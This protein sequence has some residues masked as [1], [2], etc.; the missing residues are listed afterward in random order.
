MADDPFESEIER[1]VRI[2][3]D[4]RQITT[5]S[6]GFADLR[7]RVERGNNLKRDIV[8]RLDRGDRQFTRV[9]ERIDSVANDLHSLITELHIDQMSAD[10]KAALPAMAR[11]WVEETDQ[12]QERHKLVEHRSLRVAT[13]TPIVNVTLGAL[14]VLATLLT[15]IIHH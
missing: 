8:D 9:E 1:R 4:R 15:F 11:E 5:L 14:L 10:Q 2:E 13:W 3:L 7:T 6:E 12:A